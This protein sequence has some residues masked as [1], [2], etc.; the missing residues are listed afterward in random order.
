MSEKHTNTPMKS[1]SYAKMHNVVVGPRDVI[2]KIF[3]FSGKYLSN[4]GMERQY[5]K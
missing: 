1:N 3:G 4:K 2:D 5:N